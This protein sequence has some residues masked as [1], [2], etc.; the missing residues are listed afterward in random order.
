MIIVSLFAFLQEAFPILACI[1]FFLG[2]GVMMLNA[3][4]DAISS[5]MV[6]RKV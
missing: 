6:A 2:A 5:M 1:G 3:S 4:E